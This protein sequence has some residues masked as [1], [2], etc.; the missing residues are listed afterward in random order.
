MQ[1][2]QR[3]KLVSETVKAN[4]SGVGAGLARRSK[5]TRGQIVHRQL[6]PDFTWPLRNGAQPLEALLENIDA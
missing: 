3:K 5:R 6:P 4:A 2:N 1:R